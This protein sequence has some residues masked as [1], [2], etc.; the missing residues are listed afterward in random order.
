MR[1]FCTRWV[2]RDL[3]NMSYFARVKRA[4]P[5][6]APPAQGQLMYEPQTYGLS[7]NAVIISR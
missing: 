7:P 4:G 5:S 6:T 3:L 2:G 1:G